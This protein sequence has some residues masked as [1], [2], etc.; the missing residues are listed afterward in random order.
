M[1]VQGRVAIVTG[2]GQGIGEGIAER[3]AAGGA[4]VVVNDLVA[5][6]VGRVVAALRDAG[7][8]AHGVAADVSRAEGAA[9]LIRQAAEA[10]GRVDILVNNVGIARDR[11]LTK[12]PEEDWDEVL[13]VNLKSCYLCC[14]EA[15]PLMM[16]QRYG[17]IVNIS[18]RA[19]LGNPGQVNYAASKGAIVSLTRTLA[20]ELA[21]FGITVNAIAPALVDTPLFRTLKPEIQDRLLKTVP[22]G[23][24]G[25]PADIANAAAFFAGDETEYVTGQLLYV[26]GGRS[27]GAA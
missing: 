19:W 27:V 17:R 8:Q 24:M 7:A 14:R 20:L 5:E 21:K 4:R 16:E 9:A 13:R 10:F 25:V 6:R 1:G 15:V 23:R 11:Y 18:S 26:C 12:M 2:A 3:L 22:V